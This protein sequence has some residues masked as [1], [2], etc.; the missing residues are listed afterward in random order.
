MPAHY[1]NFCR[2]YRISEVTGHPLS[3]PDTTPI[4]IAPW[5]RRTSRRA[6][7]KLLPLYS[8]LLTTY[9]DTNIYE[10]PPAA[11]RTNGHTRSRKEM[12]PQLDASQ[13]ASCVAARQVS[14]R[15]GHEMKPLLQI[16][17]AVGL[18]CLS[19]AHPV[20]VVVSPAS[21]WLKTG[22]TQKFVVTTPGY[23]TFVWSV[24]KGKISAT[25]LYRAVAGADTVTVTATPPRCLSCKGTATVNVVTP[26]M[27]YTA[28]TDQTVLQLPN[29]M[30]TW[31]GSEWS[32]NN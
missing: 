12:F 30:P 24:D 9:A 14:P 5:G 17:A 27:T 8:S 1:G 19:S 23:R 7:N 3:P 32:W 16:V 28:R 26:P 2:L 15:K 31:G 4:E 20:P 22:Q 21:V 10:F 29:P 18:S 11:A 6:L 25:G 13:R